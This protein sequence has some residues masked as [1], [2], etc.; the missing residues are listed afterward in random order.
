[1]YGS[2]VNTTAEIVLGVLSEWDFT[3]VNDQET[4]FAE[5]AIERSATGD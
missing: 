1:M 2:I 4:G 5:L 3:R